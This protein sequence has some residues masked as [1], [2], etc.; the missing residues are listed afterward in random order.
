MGLATPFP[1]LSF[2]PSTE[3]VLRLELAIRKAF[4]VSD[5]KVI[6]ELDSKLQA[7][8]K[9][10]EAVKAALDTTDAEVVRLVSERNNLAERI[11]FYEDEL[12]RADA[13]HDAKDEEIKTL[14]SKAAMG[15]LI[16]GAQMVDKALSARS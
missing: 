1:P 9:A 15:A 13:D 7:T 10:L 5:G 3:Q 2:L 16:I 11:K 14:K 12:E 8:V 4:N 6:K